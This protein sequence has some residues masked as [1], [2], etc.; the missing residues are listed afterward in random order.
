MD[1]CFINLEEE[2]SHSL[3]YARDG[4]RL[5]NPGDIYKEFPK[6]NEL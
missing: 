6:S 4:R 2:K 3:L 5:E 1:I